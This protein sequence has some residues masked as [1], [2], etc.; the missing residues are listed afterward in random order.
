MNFNEASVGT[1]LGTVLENSEI[2]VTVK[3]ETGKIVTEKFFTIV[4]NSLQLNK[5]TMLSMLTL[6]ERVIRQ[7]CLCYLMEKIKL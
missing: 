6:D 1:Q 3:D 7:D 5:K 2:P 4:D